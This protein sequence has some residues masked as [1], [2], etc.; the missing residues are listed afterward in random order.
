MQAYGIQAF[1]Q[2]EVFQRMELNVPSLRAGHV[3]IRVKATSINPVDYKI[4]AGILP[5][6]SPAFPAVLHSDVAGVIE[7]VGEG[8]TTLQVGDEVY[9]CAGGIQGMSGALAELMLAD[10]TLVARKPKS[11][12]FSQA[13]ALPLVSITAWEGLIDRAQVQPGQRVL[14]YGGTG[15]VGHI[16][17]QL[18][19]WRGAKVFAT[20]SSPK[21]AEIAK[22]LGADEVIDYRHQS[23]EDYVQQYTHDQGFDIVFDTVGNDNLQCAF[24]ATK[25]NGQVVSILALSAQDLVPMHIRGLSLHIVYMLLPM[26]T[27]INRAYHREILTKLATLVDSQQIRP[28][29]DQ[30]FAISDIAQAHRY[31]E[32]GQ[33]IGKVVVEW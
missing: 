32:S 30:V 8:V 12:S 20:T 11:L 27:G 21:K 14:V 1:G 5:D 9:A 29:I 25:I 18:A 2:P 13:A 26:L 6:L 23:A 16:A 4:R 17:I 22:Q 7:A 33:A 10:A 3:F 15:G 28:L 24:Q 19:K 31:A